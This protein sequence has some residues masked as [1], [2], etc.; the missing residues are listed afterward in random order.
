MKLTV[1]YSLLLSVGWAS[2]VPLSTEIVSP[3]F[4]TGEISSRSLLHERAIA[5][6][7]EWTALGDSYASGVGAGT[8]DEWRR[9][10]D[11]PRRTLD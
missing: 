2:P 11:F 5:S 1:Q 3:D 8:P 4:S 7:T 10:L 6:I 9:C